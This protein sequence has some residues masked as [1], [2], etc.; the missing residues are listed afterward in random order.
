VDYGHTL[1]FG[2]FLI[3]DASDPSGVPETARL[4]DHLGYDLIGV[5]DHPYQRRHFDTL[6]LLG[7][8]L[9]RTESVRVFADVH[10]LPLRPPAVLAKA[11]ATLDQLVLP[12][13]VSLAVAARGR[14]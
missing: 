8:I 12:D 13:E 4:L 11:A 14:G 10:D 2:Y 3:P 5:Q 6:S 7:V 1:E 9:A